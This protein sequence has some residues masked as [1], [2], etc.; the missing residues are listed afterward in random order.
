[1]WPTRAENPKFGRERNG[2][3]KWKLQ[4]GGAAVGEERRGE[5]VSGEYRK[6][7]D[8]ARIRIS[9]SV[10]YLRVYT[11]ISY[12]Q[13]GRYTRDSIFV[14]ELQKLAAR[15]CAAAAA[16]AAAACRCHVEQFRSSVVS[17]FVV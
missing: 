1:M 15:F 7:V 12:I 14:R 5:W 13:S 3:S 4:I 16:A 9:S 11:S 17:S 8:T 2:H 6:K 10:R